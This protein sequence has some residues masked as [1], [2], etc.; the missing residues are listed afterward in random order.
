MPTG[1]KGTQASS[2]VCGVW[3]FSRQCSLE[4]TK[5]NSINNTHLW[6]IF[7]LYFR[8]F[9]SSQPVYA[10]ATSPSSSQPFTVPSP[11]L[12]QLPQQ[13]LAHKSPE[14]DPRA[15]TGAQWPGHHPWVRAAPGQLGAQQ[16]RPAWDQVGRMDGHPGGMPLHSSLK[17]TEKVVRLLRGW[18]LV[19]F[20]S[21]MALAD[22]WTGMHDIRI[23][24]SLWFALH[25]KLNGWTCPTLKPFVHVDHPCMVNS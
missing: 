6:C 4:N 11:F 12:C 2:S 13:E 3:L 19:C 18:G 23:L 17:C 25:W 24:T 22:T 10:E 8:P 1:P 9:K 14:P 7:L 15:R 16:Q 21:L 5:E 20:E